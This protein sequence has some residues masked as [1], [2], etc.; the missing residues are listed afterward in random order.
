M[1][2]LIDVQ[3]TLLSDSDKSPIKGAKELINFLNEKN[4]PYVVITNNTKAKS[5]DFLANLRGKGLD[6]KDGSYLDPFCVLNRFIAPC[7]AALFG[8]DEFKQTIQ[9]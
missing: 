6:I 9:N 7:D 3:G 4:L 5:D 8:A 1:S 2:F